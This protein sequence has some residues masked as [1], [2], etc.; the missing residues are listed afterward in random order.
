VAE[1]VKDG[2]PVRK[3]KFSGKW[4]PCPGHPFQELA[5]EPGIDNSGSDIDRD[6]GGFTEN[7]IQ[8][9]LVRNEIPTRLPPLPLRK[10][11]NSPKKPSS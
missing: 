6:G 1:L 7:N 5:P 3:G 8:Y 11:L 4:N 9:D 2:R 10:I